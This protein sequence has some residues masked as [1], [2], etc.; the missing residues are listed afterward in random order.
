MRQK[1]GFYHFIYLYITTLR[2]PRQFVFPR[3]INKTLLLTQL[4]KHVFNMNV[5][6]E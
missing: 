6:I 2:F 5:L 1:M 4:I 3:L